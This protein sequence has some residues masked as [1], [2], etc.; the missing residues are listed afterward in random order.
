M[1]EAAGAVV[2]GAPGRLEGVP[3][4]RQSRAAKLSEPRRE[5][6]GQVK[7]GDDLGPD[8]QVAREWPRVGHGSEHRIIEGCQPLTSSRMCAAL[9]F[10]GRMGV[11]V[12]YRAVPPNAPATICSA[13]A[14]RHW[15]MVGSS[16]LAVGL[17]AWFMCRGAQTWRYILHARAARIDRE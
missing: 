12:G 5:R 11:P 2:A 3:E 16:W 10:N 17:S 4:F 15:G 9:L 8:A 1:S 7:R 13:A 14:S 6:F